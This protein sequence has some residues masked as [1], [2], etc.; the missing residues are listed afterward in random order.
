M[1]ITLFG[2]GMGAE[3]QAPEIEFQADGVLTVTKRWKGGLV[4]LWAKKTKIREPM[5]LSVLIIEIPDPLASAKCKCVSSCISWDKSQFYTL[6]EVYQGYVALPFSIYRWQT[7]R[8]ERPITMHPRFGGTFNGSPVMKYGRDWVWDLL[9]PGNWNGFPN[10]QL[11]E[12]PIPGSVDTEFVLLGPTEV[13]PLGTAN[14]YR[15]IESYVV[16]SGL[17][18]KTSFTI[19]PALTDNL[20]YFDTPSIGSEVP[21]ELYNS[22]PDKTNAGFHWIKSQEDVQN[23]YRGASQLWQMDE[24]WW[25]NSLGWIEEIYTKGGNT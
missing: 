19:K 11:K 13:P 22:I 5:P 7:Q 14:K 20:W 2:K 8:L 4:Q 3:E 12:F 24:A 1:A 21:I 18:Q 16:S 10:Y 6:T 25:Y 15:G 23:L 17:W 9:N